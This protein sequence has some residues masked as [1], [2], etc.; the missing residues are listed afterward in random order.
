METVQTTL[1]PLLCSHSICPITQLFPNLI[2]PLTHDDA[3]LAWR[4]C[5]SLAQLCHLQL[6]YYHS[7]LPFTPTYNGALHSESHSILPALAAVT[8][9]ALFVPTFSQPALGEDDFNVYYHRSGCP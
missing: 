3:T 6:H 8:H 9:S 2:L 1:P 5:T 7:H 4:A